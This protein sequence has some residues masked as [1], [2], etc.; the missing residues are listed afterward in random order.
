MRRLGRLT[1]LIITILLITVAITFATSN[2]TPITLYLWPFDGKFT[3]PTWLVVMFSFIIGGLFS[4]AVLWTQ[5]FAIRTKLWRLQ[6]K[7]NKLEAEL[8]LQQND[9]RTPNDMQTKGFQTG[10]GA[11]DQTLQDQDAKTVMSDPMRNK[12][13]L[14]W[15]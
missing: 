3:A 13:R 4:I 10:N 7:F 8:V 9:S 6:G 15:P 2:E 1:W 5:W 11:V 12:R 14:R